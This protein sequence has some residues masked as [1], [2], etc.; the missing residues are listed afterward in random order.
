[1]TSK[2][3][4]VPDVLSYFVFGAGIQIPN[5]FLNRIITRIVHVFCRFTSSFSNLVLYAA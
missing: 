3:S 4:R 1:M 2:Q 5:Q